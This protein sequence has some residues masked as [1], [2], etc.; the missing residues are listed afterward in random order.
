MRWFWEK[1]KEATI[2]DKPTF[3]AKPVTPKNKTKEKYRILDT[4][5]GHLAQVKCGN[6]WATLEYG[7][8]GNKN[9]VREMFTANCIE[10]YKKDYY[11]TISV[12]GNRIEIHKMQELKEKE[13]KL[14]HDE[15]FVSG[16]VHDEIV[17]KI[18]KR[19]EPNEN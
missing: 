17:V 2:E 4:A 14:I 13:A 7:L 19:S 10:K 11:C 15:K 8:H 9:R 12:A 18:Y 1:D 3:A 5:S 6:N 16:V